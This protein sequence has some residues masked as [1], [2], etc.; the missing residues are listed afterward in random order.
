MLEEELPLVIIG[1]KK[2]P[3]S[4]VT[5]ILTHFNTGCNSVKVRARGVGII[6]MAR[7]VNLLR[8]S[9]IKDL[10]IEGWKIEKDSIEVPGGGIKH[11]SSLELMICK[12][13]RAATAK[14]L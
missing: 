12:R 7:V 4:Y 10:S 1:S 5:A 14:S 6:N 2:P 8:E 11:L 9:F 3:L 13:K